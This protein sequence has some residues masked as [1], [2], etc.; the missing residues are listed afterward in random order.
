MGFTGFKI[1]RIQK[2][3]D[4]ETQAYT[5]IIEAPN[6]TVMVDL[7]DS[8]NRHSLQ[9]FTE[10]FRVETMYFKTISLYLTLSLEIK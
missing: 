1:N 5:A 7:H 2:F 8:K 10:H 6:G 3:K 9:H 4:E